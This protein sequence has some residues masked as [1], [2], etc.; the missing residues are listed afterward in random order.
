MFLGTRKNA[1]YFENGK[2]ISQIFRFVF[3]RNHKTTHSAACRTMRTFLEKITFFPGSIQRKNVIGFR[4]FLLTRRWLVCPPPNPPKSA[5]DKI[6][7]F[8]VIGMNRAPLETTQ[9]TACG[10]IHRKPVY[11]KI[12]ET[13]Q[14]SGLP[15]DIFG[16]EVERKMR[17]DL[18]KTKELMREEGLVFDD[19]AAKGW[20]GELSVCV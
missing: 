6:K 15:Q 20:L 18:E 17:L 11:F 3:I 4:D 2:E 7:K 8:L 1:N 5:V 12:V 16:K 14:G 9:K 19:S 10:E 13:P